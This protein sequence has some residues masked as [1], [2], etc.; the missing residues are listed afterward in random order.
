MNRQ[1]LALLFLCFLMWNFAMPVDVQAETGSVSTVSYQWLITI[2]ASSQPNLLNYQNS[3]LTPAFEADVITQPVASGSTATYEKFWGAAGN[4]LG[5]ERTGTYSVPAG[6]T[7]AFK[8]VHDSASPT[9]A[10][11]QLVTSALL[12]VLLDA[13][14]NTNPVLYIVAPSDSYADLVSCLEEQNFQNIKVLPE[15]VMNRAISLLVVD[16]TG[17]LKTNLYY[18]L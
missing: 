10:E 18:L 13:Q 1:R 6:N 17:T 12:R 11:N 7:I 16:E 3:T 5:L 15:T 14:A 8:V 4:T 9:H 2:S